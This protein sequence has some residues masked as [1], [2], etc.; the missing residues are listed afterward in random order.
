MWQKIGLILVWITEHS[1]HLFLG[2]L[3]TSTSLKALDKFVER[4]GERNPGSRLWP[5][6]DRQLDHADAVFGWFG[7]LLQK[8][9]FTRKG[10]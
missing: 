1:N 6:L 4:A 3:F 10:K 5:F 7:D 8:M 9:V 2:S